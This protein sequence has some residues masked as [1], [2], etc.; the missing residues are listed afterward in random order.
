[1]NGSGSKPTLQVNRFSFGMKWPIGQTT[2]EKMV[3]NI[4]PN[5]PKSPYNLRC[6]SEIWPEYGSLTCGFVGG[7]VLGNGRR[8]GHR[9]NVTSTQTGG[10][11]DC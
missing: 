4:G 6:P 11:I 5:G 9:Q 3:T 10:G 8:S 2:S 1:M 7:A